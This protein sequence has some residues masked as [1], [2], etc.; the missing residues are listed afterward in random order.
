[1][2]LEVFMK[3]NVLPA[4]EKEVAISKRMLD[5][6]GNPVKWT[7]QAITTR[8]DTE[9][10]QECTRVAKAPGKNGKRGATVEKL[11]VDLYGLKLCAACVVYPDLNNA[12]LQDSYGVKN[13]I[14]LLKVM[15]LPGELADLQVE[16]TDVCGFQ[17]FDEKVEEAKN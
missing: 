16:A 13:P 10:R 15:L 2:N 4:E 12:E 14:D 1:M 6:E 3:G 9:L 11:D 7:L 5:S 17:S 8:E